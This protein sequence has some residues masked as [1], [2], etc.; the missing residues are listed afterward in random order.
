MRLRIA[1]ERPIKFYPVVSAKVGE[2]N[3]GGVWGGS[4]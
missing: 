2:G 3:K 1:K 4:P